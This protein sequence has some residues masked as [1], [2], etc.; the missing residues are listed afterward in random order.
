[1]SCEPNANFP[2]ISRRAF[3]RPDQ[4]GRS[5]FRARF[6]RVFA[7]RIEDVQR[8]TKTPRGGCELSSS[9][10]PVRVRAGKY[11]P[12]HTRLGEDV[13]R[14]ATSATDCYICRSHNARY[15]AYITRC[16]MHGARVRPR[17]I[18]AEIVPRKMEKLLLRRLL[19]LRLHNIGAMLPPRRCAARCPPA[20]F[21]VGTL[22]LLHSPTDYP[23]S[24]RLPLPVHYRRNERLQRF[25]QRNLPE[26]TRST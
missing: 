19:W 20:A 10:G 21:V 24:V 23:A 12:A 4:I 2:R 22:Q 17:D 15:R 26:I 14:G 13:S 9:A 11:M 1:M 18:A 6:P 25:L 3:D 5:V 16:I 7:A 8:I